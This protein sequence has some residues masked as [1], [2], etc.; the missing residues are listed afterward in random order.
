[1]HV[2]L[3]SQE[4]SSESFY[5]GSMEVIDG[6]CSVDDERLG[7]RF[8]LNRRTKREERS[9]GEEDLWRDLFVLK[10]YP[11]FSMFFHVFPAGGCLFD[12]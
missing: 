12:G 3:R 1:M 10:F 5:E 2:L 6:C 11:C 8:H 4:P 9:G 7:W